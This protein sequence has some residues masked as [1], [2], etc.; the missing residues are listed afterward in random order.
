ML[1]D[2]SPQQFKTWGKPGIR[3]QLIDTRDNTLVT[4]FCYEGDQHSFHVLNAVSPAFTC[5]LP[6]SRF[7]VQQMQVVAETPRVAALAK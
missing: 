7:L 2:F 1:D 6:F 4:D 3:A 5:A